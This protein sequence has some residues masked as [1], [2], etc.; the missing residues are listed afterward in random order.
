MQVSALHKIAGRISSGYLYFG[1]VAV[2]I[3]M[4]NFIWGVNLS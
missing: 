2:A 4:Y 3:L 1:E